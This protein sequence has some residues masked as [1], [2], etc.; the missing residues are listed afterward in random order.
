VKPSKAELDAL[1]AVLMTPLEDFLTEK[2]QAEHKDPEGLAQRRMF[3]KAIEAVDEVRGL[4]IGW[5]VVVRFG[6]VASSVTY[7]SFG[8]WSTKAQ[9]EKA[10]GAILRAVEGTAYAVVPQMSERGWEARLGALDA[11]PVEGS[12]WAEVRKDAAAF[13]RGWNPKKER[14]DKYEVM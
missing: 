10:A 11:P 1:N 4:R 2:E 3:T 12:S 6:T 5:V 7:Q 13:K 9:A 8:S 14:R